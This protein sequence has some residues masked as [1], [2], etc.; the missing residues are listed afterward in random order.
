MLQHKNRAKA[1]SVLGARQ[2]EDEKRQAAE[3]WNVVT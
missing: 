1:M 3:A 2:A